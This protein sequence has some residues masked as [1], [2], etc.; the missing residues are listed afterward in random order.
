MFPDSRHYNKYNDSCFMSLCE[1][2]SKLG[3]CKVIIFM[4]FSDGFPANNDP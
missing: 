3:T 4:T 1:I 2:L